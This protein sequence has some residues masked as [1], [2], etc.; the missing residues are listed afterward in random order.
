MRH[1][2][3][4]VEIPVGTNACWSAYCFY[5][6]NDINNV[7]MYGYL[8][9][10]E[11]VMRGAPSSN[12]N[13]SGVQGICPAGWHVPSAAE[14]TQLF[15]Y[16][17]SVPAYRCDG[18]SNKIAKALAAPYA[19]LVDAGSC[20]VGSNQSTNNAT[21]FSALPAGITGWTVFNDHPYD[22]S[23]FGDAAYF[24]SSTEGSAHPNYM[25]LSHG[26]GNVS[27]YDWYITSKSGLSVRCVQGERANVRINSS[28]SIHCPGETTTLTAS[29]GLLGTYV[30]STGEIGENIT[31]GPGTYTVT[32]TSPTGYTEVSE[33][34]TVSY[35][36]YIMWSYPLGGDY[37]Y[38]DGDNILFTVYCSQ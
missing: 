9:N 37:V 22:Y 28:G 25:K 15:N 23:G 14:W 1:F 19:W 3:N 12:S 8:Y 24:Y 21:G 38:C 5:P 33:P 32:V 17:R 29:S 31:V 35:E 2:E 7:S 20:T 34:F 13:P 10:W 16:T 30:W 36:D 4:G 26:D 27:F 6:N 11:A 18:N